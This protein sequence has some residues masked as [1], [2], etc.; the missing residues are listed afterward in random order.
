MIGDE[1]FIIE[2]SKVPSKRKWYSSTA[3]AIVL[4]FVLS[5][6]L[7]SVSYSQPYYEKADDRGYE[8]GNLITTKYEYYIYTAKG[9]FILNKTTDDISFEPGNRMVMRVVDWDLCDYT[10]CSPSYAS[11]TIYI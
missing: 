7:I 11:Y 4:C 10:H 6:V 8:I 1:E 3:I 2:A 5:F 9:I